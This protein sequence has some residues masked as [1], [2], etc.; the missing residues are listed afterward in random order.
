MNR[1]QGMFSEEYWVYLSAEFGGD[2]WAI[3]RAD[4]T[5]DR[6]VYRDY[7]ALLGFQR[8]VIGGFSTH[9]EFGYIFNRRVEYTSATPDFEPND[10]LMLRA[11][12]VY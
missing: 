5:P 12:A 11:G 6:F 9:L 7:R 10:T 1:F 2:S 3:E 8:K 4:L